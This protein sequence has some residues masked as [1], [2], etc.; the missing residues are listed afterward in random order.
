ML[1]C[2][3]V[4]F[5]VSLGKSLKAAKAIASEVKAER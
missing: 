3:Y 2:G 4:V 5:V 1:L